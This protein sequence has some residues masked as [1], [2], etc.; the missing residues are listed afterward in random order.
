MDAANVAFLASSR[1]EASQGLWPNE[2]KIPQGAVLYRFVGVTRS[3]PA[4][5]ADGPWWF[6]FEHY[7]TIPGNTQQ[8]ESAVK[9]QR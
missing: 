4:L 5:A 1:A 6:E 3:T 7:Q 2:Y 8:F 9:I